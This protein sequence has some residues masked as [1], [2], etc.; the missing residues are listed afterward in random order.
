[1]ATYTATAYWHEMKNKAAS[2]IAAL[3]N[4]DRAPTSEE[5]A[6]RMLACAMRHGTYDEAS[7]AIGEYVEW[8]TS[9]LMLKMHEATADA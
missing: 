1:M 4:E 3:A 5:E 7:N 2:N 9:H 8:I 6:K